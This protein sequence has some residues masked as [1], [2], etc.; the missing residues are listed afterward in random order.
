M[1]FKKQFDEPLPIINRDIDKLYFETSVSFQG[2]LTIKN[3]GGGVIAGKVMSNSSAITFD[4]E[5][6]SGNDSEI[7]FH[8]DVSIYSINDI[9]KTNTVIITNGG[10]HIVEF[11]VKIVPH[12][13]ETKEGVKL[14]NLQDF[15]EYTVKWP[16]S[17]NRLFHSHEFGVWLYS[18]GYKYM[19]FYEELLKDAEKERAVSNFHIFNGYKPKNIIA[20]KNSQMTVKIAP[21]AGICQGNLS[22]TASGI[23]HIDKQ[24]LLKSGGD[25]IKLDSDRLLSSHFND[26]NEGQIG[27]LIEPAKLKGKTGRAIISIDEEEMELIAQKLDIIEASLEKEF[28]S[29]KASS[30]IYIKNNSDSQ[31]TVEISP[32]D[33]FIKLEKHKLDI[34]R[35][36][37]IPFQIELS[38]VQSAQFALIRQPEVKTEIFVNAVLKN[39]KFAQK[40][41]LTVGWF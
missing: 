40:L 3:D 18:S 34:T 5:E 38:T 36:V 23:G 28:L 19:D 12:A 25:W 6:F 35:S 20:F 33:S 37:K 7:L 29:S 16:A 22:I 30:F 32:K 10:E 11:A 41:N 27:F 4:P 9:L 31:I 17:A 13:I 15:F 8:I 39:N 21:H 2:Q 14:I 1:D 24:I 26:K